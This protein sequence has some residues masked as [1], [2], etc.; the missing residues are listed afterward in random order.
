MEEIYLICEGSR[1][2]RSVAEATH[3]NSYASSF[4][5]Q[6]SVAHAA[7]LYVH[8]MKTILT[9]YVRIYARMYII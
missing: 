9:G 5:L 8:L 1:K 4:V 2:A 7:L 3:A 6:I